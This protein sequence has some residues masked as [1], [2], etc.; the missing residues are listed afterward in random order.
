M[1]Q[2]KQDDV[3]NARVYFSHARGPF[4]EWDRPRFNPDNRP[5]GVAIAGGGSRAYC[6]GAGQLRA[7]HHL[8]LID[9]VGA[10]SYS[11]G[12]T[13]LGV[14][15]HFAN[16]NINEQTL[17]GPV[18]EPAELTE[19][20]VNSS[21]SGGALVAALTDVPMIK[22][23]VEL[24]AEAL[25]KGEPP[26]DRIFGRA[27]GKSLFSSF[28]IDSFDQYFTLDQQSLDDALHRNPQLQAKDF[29]KMR[30]QRPYLLAGGTLI[31]PEG[32]DN[33]W[34]QCEYTPLYVGVPQKY[35][36]EWPS[37]N[38]LG[39]GWVEPLGFGSSAPLPVTSS[40]DSG[41]TVTVPAPAQHFCLSTMAGS[42]GASFGINLVEKGYGYLAP[43]FQYW[44]PCQ[45]AQSASY[46][47]VDSGTVEN[48]AIVNL[49]RRGYKRIIA[50]VNSQTP[51]DP[52]TEGHCGPLKVHSAEGIDG[53]I[54]RLFGVPTPGQDP[55]FP[56]I[57]VFPTAQL[58]D[59]IE[60]FHTA[61]SQGKVATWTDQYTVTENNFFEVPPYEVE[62]LWI[63]L[64]D[65]EQ[66]RDQITDEKVRGMF[67]DDNP[68]DYMTNFP[69][70]CADKQN[71]FEILQYSPRQANL[72]SNLGCWSAM[73]VLAP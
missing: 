15:Y 16:S 22:E 55:A 66:W 62:M 47:I 28:G 71:E 46:D 20:L 35:T 32:A 53:E 3:L 5:L 58:S 45:P 34:I 50:F 43:N 9:Q 18:T 12:S 13:W 33:L 21:D 49:L 36:G 44:S 64:T 19:E 56:D 39:G 24:F 1:S 41:D 38:L 26:L 65:V 72:L 8:N 59:L 27:L 10:I 63:Y 48:C 61:K 68:L 23:G 67:A 6:A 40:D 14:P 54:T 57:Q 7:L 73:Q 37:G 42:S 11:S 69:W 4:P 60:A 51:I 70:F 30:D 29:V 17:L 2:I 52:P 25:L 31:A